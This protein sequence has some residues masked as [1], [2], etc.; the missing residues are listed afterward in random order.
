MFAKLAWPIV[1]LLAPS[2]ALAGA[3]TVGRAVPLPIQLTEPL[4]VR[5]FGQNLEPACL[6]IYLNESTS[7][8][9]YAPVGVDVELAD[10]LHTTLTGDQVLCGF[11]LAYYN[12]GEGLVNAVVTFYAGYPND[13]DR[14][15]VLAGPYPIHGLPTGINAFHIEVQGGLL[16]A[17]LWLGVTFSDGETGLLTFGPPTLGSS[18]DIVWYSPPVFPSGF[19]YNFGGT[20][21]ADFFLGVHTSPATPAR[22]ATWGSLKAQ[23]R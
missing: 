14:G 11:D 7:T 1:L 3:P 5:D 20:P 17:N 22:P 15:A 9:F 2:S 8:N 23:Y 21:V 16:Q 12:P 10:D 19:A 6:P 13:V 4:V 18:H